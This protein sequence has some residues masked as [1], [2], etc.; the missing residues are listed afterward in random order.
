MSEITDTALSASITILETIGFID[1]IAATRGLSVTVFEVIG[2]SESTATSQLTHYYVYKVIGII[3]S[4][5]VA[6]GTIP[7]P[8]TE[9]VF[10]QIFFSLEM[11]GYLGP[12]ALVIGGYVVANKDKIL[13]VLW[14]VV[15][16][17][18]ISQYLTL[19]EATP[20]YW[21]HIFILLIG[22]FLTCVFPLW[23]R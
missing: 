2:L 7:T 9:S 5:G 11:W 4:I 14:F 13:G 3:S 10:Y 23:V 15:E 16:C 6:G 19:V 20:D 21:W 22:G 17:L 8:Q 1:L 18:F 12:I